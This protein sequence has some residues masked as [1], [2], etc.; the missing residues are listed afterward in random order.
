MRRILW[1]FALPLAAWAQLDD[2]TLTV[3]ASR[4]LPG[5]Q[6]DQAV[7]AV[8]V[9]SPLDASLDD[10]VAALAGAGISAAN[11]S[12]VSGGGGSTTSTTTT[13]TTGNPSI[14][15]TFTLT[16]PLS[17]LG[18]TI[19][20]LNATPASSPIQ[21]NYSVYSQVSQALQASQQ[22]PYPLLVADAQGQA[23]KLA[24]AAGAGVG[25]ILW[26][27]DGSVGTPGVLNV[28]PAERV[29]YFASSIGGIL[30]TPQPATPC[31][32]TVQF[33]LSH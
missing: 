6:P 17:K 28:V 25:P 1:L 10:V 2:N 18:S 31:T 9:N 4:T 5:L 21:V 23:Q 19:A 20:A 16:V 11:L 26:V 30:A 32:M 12:G 27:S 29:G 3:S 8:Y 13:T 24:A 33:S 14:Q 7:F 22:C 15:W